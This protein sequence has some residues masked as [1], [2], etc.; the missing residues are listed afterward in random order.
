MIDDCGVSHRPRFGDLRVRCRE[1]NVADGFKGDSVMSGVEINEGLRRCDGTVRSRVDP[2]GSL[3]G[4]KG[5]GFESGLDVV[6]RDER[7]RYN[8]A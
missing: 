7:R 2:D 1:G 4:S 8:A 5:D 6:A 3:V